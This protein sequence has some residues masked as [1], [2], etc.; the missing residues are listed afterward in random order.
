MNDHSHGREN[1]TQLEERLANYGVLYHSI[2]GH[3]FIVIGD[4]TIF[5]VEEESPTSV[6]GFN[7]KEIPYENVEQFQVELGDPPERYQQE[8]VEKVTDNENSKPITH[9]RLWLPSD[10]VD[11]YVDADPREVA[12]S[13]V[14]STL[15]K[16]EESDPQQK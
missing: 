14:T 13:F 6:D 5:I 9:I 15:N 12:S 10:A 2:D 7:F 11:T 16:T 1:A 3:G 4:D 8:G